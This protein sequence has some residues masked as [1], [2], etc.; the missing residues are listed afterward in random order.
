M[1]RYPQIKSMTMMSV[2]ASYYAFGHKITTK[3]RNLQ[4]FLKENE[5]DYNNS[6]FRTDVVEGVMRKR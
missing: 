2:I 1:S 3:K 5:R 4:N 6:I